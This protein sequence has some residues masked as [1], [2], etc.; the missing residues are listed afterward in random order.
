MLINRNRKRAYK[1]G[2]VML[3]PFVGHTNTDTDMRDADTNE[4]TNTR[5]PHVITIPLACAVIACIKRYCICIR[6][7]AGRHWII[8]SLSSRKPPL[9][10]GLGS[11]QSRDEL[12]NYKIIMWHSL[13]APERQG[14]LWYC[15]AERQ[16]I[17]TI[18]YILWI[19]GYFHI[20][21]YHFEFTYK[22]NLSFRSS[23]L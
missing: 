5:Q 15:H 13:S 12:T 22:A 3:M 9:F 2:F 6:A 23:K 11:S 7:L 4:D 19:W 18:T 20:Q 14:R 10:S 8:T 21:I 17:Y 1:Q 16:D